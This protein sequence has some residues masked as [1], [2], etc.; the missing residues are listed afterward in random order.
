MAKTY[1]RVWFTTATIGTGTITVLA[2]VTNVY[3]TPAE[4]SIPNG[5]VVR[6]VLEDLINGAWEVGVGVYTSSGTTLSRGLV[7]SSTGSLISLSGSATCMIVP[8]VQD[9]VAPSAGGCRL[10]LSSAV[11][12]MPSTSV[13]GATTV[14]LTPYLGAYVPVWDGG[15]YIAQPLSEISQAT[16]DTT[17]SPAAAVANTCY[18]MLAWV[19]GTTLRCTRGWPW[20]SDTSRGTGA[21]SAQVSN[22]G[23]LYV[24]AAPVTNGPAAGM[25]T[26]VGTIRTNGASQVDWAP[27]PGA[28]AGG[29][30][31]RV[32]VWN[33]FNRRPVTLNSRDSTGSWSYTS[34]TARALNNSNS[35][36][37][38]FV[39][40]FA[41]D[42]IEASVRC[43]VWPPAGFAYLGMALDSVTATDAINI[44]SAGGV[45][46]GTAIPHRYGPQIGW[47][48]IQAMEQADGTN[49]TI[50]AASGEQDLTAT[51]FC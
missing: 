22:V 28:A 31:A 37:L 30:N 23:G 27:Q 4:A 38:S 1:N 16:T 35:N 50:Y 40:G 46:F 6:Y 17:K 32:G 44:I 9:V 3:R 49:S 39:S 42:G 34:A 33:F 41:E 45:G 43:R 51:V 14:Y 20:A 19:D 48:Y 8:V 21:G 10:T 2:A 24:N 12:V 26:V 36:R 15:S 11:P 7:E 5:A 25:G 13:T 18:D 47:H 29:S